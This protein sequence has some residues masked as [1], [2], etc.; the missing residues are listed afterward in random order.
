MLTYKLLYCLMNQNIKA[1]NLELTA[2]AYVPGRP[3]SIT[4]K[5]E[6]CFFQSVFTLSKVKKSRLS[7]FVIR[8]NSSPMLLLT[9]IK[10]DGY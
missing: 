2:S 6:T 4:Y 9:Q 10:P 7:S 1:E 3:G 5:Y 8:E